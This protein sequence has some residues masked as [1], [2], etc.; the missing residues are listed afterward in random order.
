[1][2]SAI[3][4]IRRKKIEFLNSCIEFLKIVEKLINQKIL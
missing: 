2:V 4:K 1:M 3:K